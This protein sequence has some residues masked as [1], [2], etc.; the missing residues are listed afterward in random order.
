MVI[1]NEKYEAALNNKD[2]I[3]IMHSAGAGF[4]SILDADELHRCKLMALWKALQAWEE[5]RGTKFT[6]FLYQQVK[7]ECLKN[8][9]QNKTRD[10]QMDYVE[11]AV[12]PDTPMYELLDGLSDDL[13]DMVEKRY[14]YGMTLREIGN[15]Y[16]FCY[17]TIRKRLKKARHYMKA[18]LKG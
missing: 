2:N 7:W 14:V 16:G 15:E 1:S 13:K 6:G 5:D 4:L 18:V 9:H 11:L 17:E 10:I 12:L 3:M 8:I